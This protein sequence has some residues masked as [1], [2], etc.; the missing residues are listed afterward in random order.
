MISITILNFAQGVEVLASD[1]PDP[2]GTFGLDSIV[3][4]VLTGTTAEW[5]MIDG[6]TGLTDDVDTVASVNNKDSAPA[7]YQYKPNVTNLDAESG[8]TCAANTPDNAG[9][10]FD[11]PFGSGG[12]FNSGNWTFYVNESDNR[13]GNVGTIQVCVW[14]V[15]VSGGTINTYNLLFSHNDTTDVWDG[16]VN[17]FSFVSSQGTHSI[18]PDEYLYVEYF[19]N[20]T[21]ISSAGA[22]AEFTSTFRVGPTYSNPRIVTPTVKIPEKVSFF[23]TVAPFIPLMVLWL[24]QRRGLALIKADKR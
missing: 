3:S 2:S 6:I 19:T 18:G 10:I 5:K 21:T 15:T 8:T 9:W 14:R 20:V 1:P 23:I 7:W 22:G 12:Q 17:N 11:T 13:V 4:T 16:A 24:R